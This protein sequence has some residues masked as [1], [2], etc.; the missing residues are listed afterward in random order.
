M[1]ST[2]KISE[3]FDLLQEKKRNGIFFEIL[4]KTTQ[5]ESKRSSERG[6]PDRRGGIS[7]KRTKDDARKGCER[8]NEAICK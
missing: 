1:R 3:I 7:S 4:K 5:D 2:V 8:K 6:V